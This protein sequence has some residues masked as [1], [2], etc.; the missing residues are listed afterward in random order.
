MKRNASLSSKLAG[1]E[2]LGVAG[3]SLDCEKAV[4]RLV[5]SNSA[6]VHARIL[7][8]G[9][10]HCLLL[11]NPVGDQLAVKS[12]FSSGYGGTGPTCFS[13]V[14]QMLQTHGCEID[15]CYVE[16]HIIERLDSSALTKSDVELVT[17]AD[18]IRPGRWPDYILEMHYSHSQDGGFW[19][20]VTPT[21]PYPLIDERIFDL[22]LLFQENADTAL[23]S[24]YRRLEDVIRERTSASDH[25]H[26][27]FQKAFQGDKSLL[28]WE[29]ID[30]G[31]QSGRANLFIGAFL[32]HRNPRAHRELQADVHKHLS[33]FLLLNHLFRLERD[34]VARAADVAQ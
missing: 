30:E 33:E 22:A 19:R 16:Q 15:E 26:R 7:T 24:G 1:I 11:T 29:D 27:L 17:S 14:L 20:Y 9:N 8:S 18:A 32:A 6:P 23:I 28:R 13:L 21:M 34:A 31:E 12:G 25:G 3:S 10:T 5:Q 2:Y 4:V